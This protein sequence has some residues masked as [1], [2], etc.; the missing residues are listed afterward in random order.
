LI[1][2]FVLNNHYDE[3]RLKPAMAY[4]K[5]WLDY[6]QQWIRDRE[7]PINRNCTRSAAEPSSIWDRL[8]F[9]KGR[10]D[11]N[12]TEGVDDACE[13]LP[14]VD[15]A[16]RAERSIEDELDK[17]SQGDIPTVVISYGIMFAYIAITLGQVSLD[18]QVLLGNLSQAHAYINSSTMNRNCHSL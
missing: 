9:G 7:M 18:D 13:Y 4:E 11:K 8:F 16:F 17:Q 1:I 2:T 6:V 12:D 10:D 14:K 3:E 15:V 5:A